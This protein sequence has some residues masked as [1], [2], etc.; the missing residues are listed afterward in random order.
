MNNKCKRCNTHQHIIS[1]SLLL[2][3]TIFS[4]VNTYKVYYVNVYHIS[5][6]YYETH[7]V[8]FND[9]YTL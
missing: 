4:S 2:E 1:N 6:L 3:D 8:R 5:T 9:G 7:F